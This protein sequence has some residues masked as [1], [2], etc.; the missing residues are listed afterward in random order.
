MARE[1]LK[2]E[3]PDY[4]KAGKLAHEA[5]DA[6]DNIL[7][8]A[9]NEHEAAERLRAK[10]VS[11]RR[12]AN[13]SVSIASKYIEVHH[14][15]VRSEAR[16]YLVKA[17]ESLRQAEAAADVDSQIAL[18]SQ[19]ESEADRAYQ[20]AQS[21][22]ASTTMIIPRISIPTII[23]PPMSP[24]GRSQQSWGYP[25]PSSHDFGH[26]SGSGGGFFRPGGGT[27]RSGGG[28]SSGWGAGGRGGGGGGGSRRGG[29]SSG[30]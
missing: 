24:P 6:A 28:G 18:A 2:Q 13:S 7:I 22:V 15:E 19:A 30:W 17:V 25:R 3:K 5:N 29:G 1:E 8:Q 27:I 4:F 26:N 14:P 23:I 9:R 20:L 11:L 16:N 21:D 10:A 12:E